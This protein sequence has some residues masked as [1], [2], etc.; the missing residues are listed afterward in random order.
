MRY[1]YDLEGNKIEATGGCIAYDAPP[2]DSERVKLVV[3][4]GKERVWHFAYPPKCLRNDKWSKPMSLFHKSWQD[5]FEKDYREISFKDTD[6]T[7]HRADISTKDNA[8]LEIQNSS[9]SA[10]EVDQRQDFYVF[11]QYEQFLERF[12][13]SE[14]PPLSDQNSSP[15]QRNE[16][17]SMNWILNARNF[18]RIAWRPIFIFKPSLTTKAMLNRYFNIPGTRYLF[19]CDS[20]WK[21]F[22]LETDGRTFEIKPVDDAHNYIA[23]CCLMFLKQGREPSTPISSIFGEVLKSSPIERHLYPDASEV[24]KDIMQQAKQKCEQIQLFQEAEEKRDYDFDPCL[25]KPL[26]YPKSYYRYLQ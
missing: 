17:R 7:I 4:T 22:V 18:G 16:C 25:D 23:H 5:L 12:Y 8:V 19:R 9:I 26:L 20:I 11:N 15:T 10:K 21:F 6:G 14:E 2:N 1:G 3:K 24:E 13:S